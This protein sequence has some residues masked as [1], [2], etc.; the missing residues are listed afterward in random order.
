M[1]AIAL[2]GQTGTGKSDLAMRIAEKFNTSIVCC[3]SMQVYQKL[4][5]GTAKASLEEQ[6]RVPHTMLDCCALPDSFSAAR[7][8]AHA[9]TI[10]REENRAGRTPLI[11]GGTGLYL[12]A[13]TEGF[14]DI[15][16]EQAGVREKF[17]SIGKTHGTAALH[18]ILQEKDV[19][20]A[21][22]LKP[23]DTQ[24]IMR[25]LCVFESTGKPLSAWQSQDL[26]NKPDIRCPVFVMDVPR[27]VLRQGI[28]R[29][30][31]GMLDAG[32][33]DEVQWLD[34]LH[35]PDTHPAMRAVGYRQLLA[36]VRGECP[37]SEAMGAGITATQR[38]AK[39]QRTWFAHQTPDTTWGNTDQLAPRII[40]ALNA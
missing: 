38:Y 20:M 5:I 36:H 26:T 4:D 7:W 34:S 24:R 29:R 28:A 12:K 23:G 25:A 37:L 15:P 21:A 33:V 2:M 9:A 18:R 22:R 3:D 14:P 35:L 30:F 11:V 32:W 8:A 40:E 1:N 17:Q 31:Q 13:L 16:P 10:I 6:S 27:D 19:E 39:R